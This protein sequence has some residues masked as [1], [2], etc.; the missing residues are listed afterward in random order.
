MADFNNKIET[1]TS[2]LSHFVCCG[3]YETYLGQYMGVVSPLERE[4]ADNAI[5]KL[6]VDVIS[7]AFWDILPFKV[8]DDFE[9]EYTSM[10][11]PRYYNFETDSANFTFEYSDDLK[12]WFFDYVTENRTAF[13]KFLADNYTSRSGFISFTPNNWNDWLNGWNE[14][15][16]RCVSALLTFLLHDSKADYDEYQYAFDDDA[17]TIIEE[18]YIRYEWAEKFANGYIGAVYSEWDDDE[19]AT[20]Y[21]AY[22]LDTDGNVI[23]QAKV[24]DPYDDD[25]HCSAYAAWEYSWLQSDLTKKYT[26]CGTHSEPCEVPDIETVKVA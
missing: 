6:A 23:N 3:T 24:D 9:C 21:T 4:A 19:Q 7:E 20:V 22:L 12:E 18:N 26:L 25:F 5:G 10:Y 14:S 2:A 8:R 1:S 11:S 17:R 15:D 16:W 13:E